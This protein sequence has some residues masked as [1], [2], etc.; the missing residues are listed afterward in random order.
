MFVCICLFLECLK[1]IKT[2][3]I[4]TWNA[5]TK[6]NGITFVDELELDRTRQVYNLVNLFQDLWNWFIILESC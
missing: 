2:F 3:S 1:L 4:D 5:C 6:I